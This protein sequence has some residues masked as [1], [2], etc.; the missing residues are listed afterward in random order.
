MRTRPRI[1]VHLESRASALR[2]EVLDDGTGL[3]D[4]RRHGATG[5]IAMENRAATIGATIVVGPGP[6]GRG[7]A[8][9][10]DVPTTNNG[11]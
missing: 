10:L 5:L 3:P 2:L 6:G 11:G 1:D 9:L 7:T 4:E 8:I